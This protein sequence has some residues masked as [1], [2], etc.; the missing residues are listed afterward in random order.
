MEALPW[1][2]EKAA[3]QWGGAGDAVDGDVPDRGSA[4]FLLRP[5]GWAAE[6]VRIAGEAGWAGGSAGGDRAAAAL[7][8]A[9]AEIVELREKAR[10]L[11][12][13]STEARNALRRLEKAA[14][15]PGRSEQSDVSR[16]RQRHAAEMEALRT[17][18]DEAA[19]ALEALGEEMLRLREDLKKE[20]RGRASAEHRL[21][22]G[23]TTAGWSKGGAELARLL[24]QVA[25]AAIRVLPEGESVVG[26]EPLRLGRGVLPDS[27]DAVDA[28]LQHKGPKHIVVDGYNVGLA[29]ASGKAGEVRARL[30]PVLARLRA[31]ARPPRSVTV[32][33]DSQLEGSDG[34]KV[35]GVSGVSVRFTAP[36]SSADD[37]I[38][39]MAAPGTVV[40]SNDRA[41][42]ERSERN[43]AVA[44][45]SEALVAWV[46]KR[47]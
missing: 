31:L 37:V 41:V 43:G 38:V 25:V 24:D 33:Y 45:W 26:V 5:E 6:L 11:N 23:R 30:E 28:V 42:R 12:R 2:R 14:A 34:F 44:L 20:R 35:Q 22:E 1:L 18:R 8:K 32:V 17:Q 13:E 47:R 40:I 36:G 29:L 39:G 21:Q 16:L 4:L 3:D 27:A 10:N 9:R 46:R 7:D 15:A 19:A